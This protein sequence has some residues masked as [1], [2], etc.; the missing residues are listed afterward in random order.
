MTYLFL[1][2]NIFL[3][4]QAYDQLNWKNLIA[5]DEYKIVIPRIILD[6]LDKKKY[7]ASPKI[8]LRATSVLSKIS[9]VLDDQTKDP[10]LFISPIWP[11]KKTYEN[12]D[13]DPDHQDDA[14]LAS[15]LEFAIIYPEDNVILVTDDTGIKAR[16]KLLNLQVL[17]LPSQYRL[18]AEK[19]TEEKELEKVRKELHTLRNRLPKVELLFKERRQTIKLLKPGPIKSF[20]EFRSV[21]MDEIQQKHP[22]LIIKPSHPDDNSYDNWLAS[23]YGIQDYKSEYNQQLREFFHEYEI[24]L[25]KAYNYIVSESLSFELNLEL[26]NAGTC[27]ATDISIY[28]HFPDGFAL[29]DKRSKAPKPP[30]PPY[31]PKSQFD[32]NV[33]KQ[34]ALPTPSFSNLNFK[35]PPAPAEA[36]KPFIK[37]TNSYEVKFEVPRLKHSFGLSLDKLILQYSSVEDLKNFKIEYRLHL[38]ELP[39]AVSGTLNVVFAEPE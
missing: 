16:A 1:D 28:V 23:T 39:A 22:L 15:M 24:F 34:T 31:R 20:E 9:A 10:N 33:M 38:E 6:E 29:S 7:Q 12:H 36:G 13:L 17:S 19:S 30:E 26:Q 5:A 27:P 11:K 14:L 35:E 37:K 8:S 3:H 25:Q 2:T 4:F 21:K 18:P 32:Y